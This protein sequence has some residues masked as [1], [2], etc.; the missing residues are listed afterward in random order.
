MRRDEAIYA[1]MMV[2]RKKTGQN[3]TE[4]ADCDRSKNLFVDFNNVKEPYQ[5]AIACA[6]QNGI[7]IG[8]NNI[9][10]P[11]RPI[12][13]GELLTIIGRALTYIGEM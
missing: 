4:Y 13:R 11:D 8:Y 2:Y 7:V 1:V 5:Q 9:L 6:I 3:F 10:E 12:T